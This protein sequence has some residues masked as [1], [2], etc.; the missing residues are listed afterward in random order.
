MGIGDGK[1]HMF[2]LNDLILII[3]IFSSMLAGILLPDWASFFRP[4]PIYLM[5]L[6]LFLSFLSISIRDIW[7]VVRD[8]APALVWLSFLK[9]ILVPLVVYLAF[10]T[11]YPPYAT[12]ALLITGISTGVVAP[13]ISTLV[14]GNAHLVLVVVVISS[15]LVPF[16]LPA[17][18]K[19]LLGQSVEISLAAM[20]QT[21]CMVIFIPILAV[22]MLKRVAPKVLASIHRRRYPIS[23]IIFAMVNLG[24]FSSYSA[25]FL[26]NPATIL[27]AT[28]VAVALGA[29][30]LV[31]GIVVLPKAPVPDRIAS[32][33]IFG[34]MNNILVIVFA[35]E[36]FGPLEPTV[37]AMYMIPFFGLILP[38]RGYSRIAQ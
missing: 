35:A 33:I 3:V 25:F 1:P 13:F 23:L 10:K 26:Q 24:V 2:R 6:L 38:L 31:V 14:N 22:E 20:T 16:T 8:R 36:F 37:A 17:L 30:Y 12:A 5:M 27:E 4:F 28:C 11:V 29:I 7:D 15:L 21:L 18:V 9:L 32:V 19:V 34:N